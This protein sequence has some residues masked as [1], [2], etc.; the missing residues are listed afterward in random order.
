MQ[1]AGLQLQL[2][3]SRSYN[4]YILSS[5]SLRLRS[6]ISLFFIVPKRLFFLSLNKASYNISF[7]FSDISFSFSPTSFLMLP[8]IYLLLIQPLCVH[9]LFLL[10]PVLSVLPSSTIT[11]KSGLKVC[12]RY[13]LT[14]RAWVGSSLRSCT[15]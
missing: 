13:Q 8:A 6:D 12:D 3:L 14:A 7:I 4:I 5:W 15:V 10:H 1:N 9:T 2:I 11:H